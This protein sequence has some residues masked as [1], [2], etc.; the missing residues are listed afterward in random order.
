MD[1]CMLQ[2]LKHKY[3]VSQFHK[4]I[5]TNWALLNIIAS[6]NFVNLEDRRQRV[7]MLAW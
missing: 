5:V 1:K 3:E 2:L 4:Q 7:L 6:L